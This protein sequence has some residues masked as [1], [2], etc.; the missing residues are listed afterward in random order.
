[1]H[2]PRRQAAAEGAEVRTTISISDSIYRKAKRIM[3]VRD[4]ADFSGLL[5][6]LI[7]EEYERRIDREAWIVEIIATA[8]GKPV[9]EVRAL[10]DAR[11]P[12][13][14]LELK[15]ERRKGRAK[16]STVPVL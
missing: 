16:G 12:Q 5:H 13:A 15:R 10:I 3:K 7:R 4:F 11:L 1:M 2:P 8:I 14:E 9:E 6:Q